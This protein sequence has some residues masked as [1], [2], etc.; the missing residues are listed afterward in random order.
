[1]WVDRSCL[2]C[3]LPDVMVRLVH[4]LECLEPALR[5]HAQRCD[6]VPGLPYVFVLLCGRDPP[7]HDSKAWVLKDYTSDTLD[8][9]SHESFRE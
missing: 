3:F 2:L 4:L 8:L 5:T 9:S 6:A 1:M 7:D